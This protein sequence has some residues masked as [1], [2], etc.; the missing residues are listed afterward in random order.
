MTISPS[1][2]AAN[3]GPTPDSP[4]AQVTPKTASKSSSPSSSPKTKSRSLSV[5]VEINDDNGSPQ[6]KSLAEKREVQQSVTANLSPN[7]NDVSPNISPNMSPNISP[8][9]SPLPSPQAERI[10]LLRMES[11]NTALIGTELQRMTNKSRIV[12]PGSG[13]PGELSEGDTGIEVQDSNGL[14]ANKFN[15]NVDN[16]KSIIP[17]YPPV[18]A[19]RPAYQRDSSIDSLD[20]IESHPTGGADRVSLSGDSGP[21]A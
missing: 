21:R 6:K 15:T 2:I 8:N 3:N 9:I 5:S 4:L 10:G 16:P 12:G 18:R 7:N 19:P 13:G 14:N 11:G 17:P 1:G 20:L